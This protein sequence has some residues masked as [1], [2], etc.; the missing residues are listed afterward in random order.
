ML[1][2]RKAD[3]NDIPL[4]RALTFTI[5]P[6][7]Y[8]AIL[9]REQIEYMLEMMYS[10]PSLEHQIKDLKHQFIIGY[11]EDEPVAF[12]SYAPSAT[13]ENIYKLHKIYILP[14]MQGKGAGKETIQYIINDIVPAG[15]RV[16]ELNVNR[17]NKAKSFYEKTGF[18]VYGTEDKDIGNGYFMNDYVMRKEL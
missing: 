12:A 4:I 18:L 1:Q 10:V 13:E 16:L 15:A 9:S 3:L 6:A 7:T 17:H 2:F 8:S 5:W 11:H 14:V